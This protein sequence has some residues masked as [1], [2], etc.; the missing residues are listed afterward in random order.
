MTRP[1]NELRHTE[2]PASDIKGARR[3]LACLLQA[4]HRRIDKNRIGEH[5]YRRLPSEMADAL[6]AIVVS[7]RS[8]LGFYRSLCQRFDVD[9]SG[10][11]S[12]WGPIEA[13]LTEGRA[14]WDHV[15]AAL[16]YGHIKTV[17]KESPEFFATFACD[18]SDVQDD[19]VF[20]A[21]PDPI[22]P[23][24][25]RPKLPARLVSPRSYRAIW[26]TT[27]PFHHGADTKTGNVNLF[28][29]HRSNDPLTGMASEVPFKSGNSIR[30]AWRDMAMG[31]H[32]QL[33]GLKATDI[34]PGRAHSMLAG[35]AVEQGADTG[36][37]NNLIRSRARE[38]CPPWDLFAGCID[39]QIMQGRALV[40]DAT[41]VCRET[42]WKV[43][44]IVAPDMQLEEFAA[45]L[46]VAD[47]VMEIRQLTRQKHADIADS[48][49]VQMLAHFECVRAGQQFVHTIRLFGIDGIEPT[50]ASFLNH[51]L[52]E[53]RAWSFNGAGQ[54]RGF[55]DIA[56][57]GY[58]RGPCA[59][60]LPP[61]DVYLEYVQSRRDEMVDW[62]MKRNEPA[63]PQKPK[64]EKR[65]WKGTEA[66]VAQ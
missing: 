48:D 18:R 3:A 42:A 50:T 25:Y 46:P 36:T 22:Q 5:R 27:S 7:E 49:G 38:L 66:E 29:R 54:A 30:G 2:I 4:T 8:C 12:E 16:D 14:R 56:I 21:F 47:E 11:D 34:P 10:G 32:L 62:L 37:V 15:C 40:G 64:R 60:E 57:E 51:L 17:I 41:L 24:L 33:L 6:M 44:E 20:A 1:A 52:S 35:G 61:P 65:N 23:A 19:S 59:P 31:V 39:Q 28:R 45:S 43:H 55:G 53:F 9:P 63:P 26:T 58:E 13:W